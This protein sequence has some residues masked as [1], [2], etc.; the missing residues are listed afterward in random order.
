MQ[1]DRILE[2][3]GKLLKRKGS[4][5]MIPEKCETEL[6]KDFGGTLIVHQTFS[7]FFLL[8]ILRIA[9]LQITS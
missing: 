9:L 7:D 2:E 1:L 4:L 5:I 8:Y 6:W 3:C